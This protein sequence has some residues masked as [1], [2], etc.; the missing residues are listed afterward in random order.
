MGSQTPTYFNTAAQGGQNT[1]PFNNT[2]TSRQVSWFIGAGTMG[3]LPTAIL[4][5]DVYINFANAVTK[6]YPLMEIKLKISAGTG[7][8][9]FPTG[10]VETGFTTVFSGANFTL[11]TSQGQWTKFPLQTPFLWSNTSL[12]IIV[13]FQHNSTTGIGPNVNQPVTIAGPGSGRQWADFNGAVNTGTATNQVDFGIDGVP[14]LITTAVSCSALGSATAQAFGTG[15]FTYTWLPGM[16]TSSVVT[17]IAPGNHTVVLHDAGLNLTYT[18]P[19]TFTPSVPYTATVQSANITCAG[20]STGSAVIS[21]GGGS[22]NTG[23]QWNN[24]ITT[25][26]TPT[27]I[28]LAPGVYSV[29]VTDLVTGCVRNQ[30]FS[31]GQ[32]PP[33]SMTIAASSPTACVGG[34]VS[35]AAVMSG[36][37]PPYSYS[38]TA[39]PATA[40][41]SVTPSG[42]GP[43]VYTVTATDANACPSGATVGITSFTVPIVA[44]QDVSICPGETGTLVATG[45]TAYAWMP[46]GSTNPVFSAQPSVSSF[47]TVSGTM[48]G[49]SSEATAA[50]VVKPIP[51]LLYNTFSIT[52]ANLGSATVIP[53]GGIGPFTYTWLPVNQTGATVSGLNPNTYTVI[54][55]DNATGC[56]TNTT[57]TFGSL[58]PLTGDLVHSGSITCFGGTTGTGSFVNVAGGS[59]IQNYL[60]TN[61]TASLSTNT[62][63]TLSAGQWSLTVTDALTG[64]QVF[65]VFTI[66]QPPAATLTLASPVSSVCVGGS[67]VLT[68]TNSGG[69]PGYTYSWTGGPAAATRT[70]NEAT[71][72]IYVYTL[73]SA[74]SFSCLSVATI[75]VDFVPNPVV[76]LSNVSVCPLETG[77]LN[78][79]GASSYTWGNGSNSTT[80]SDAPFASKL[81]TVTGAALGCTS[82]ATASIVIKPLPV[83]LINSNSPR[84]ENGSLQLNGLGGVAYTWTGPNGFGS[85]LQNPLLNGLT[86]NNGGTY[87]LTV[88]AANSCTASVSVNVVVNPTPAVS[89]T[90]ATLCSG[91]NFVLLANSSPGVSYQWTGPSFSSSL[92]N[93]FISNAPVSA[94]GDYSVKVTSASGCSN[95]AVAKVLVVP[96]PSL[97][98]QLTSHS[99]CSQAFNGSPNTI[100]LTAGGATVYSLVT[101]PDM[102]NASP[103]GP[104]Y[105]LSAIPPNT[106]IASAT[107]SGSNGICTVTIA[108][109]F[110]IIPNPT[111]SVAS[112]TPQICAGQSYTYTSHGASSY[113]WS[114]A[115][116]GFTTY[117]N[118]GVA[119]AHPSINSVFSVYGGSLGCNSAS[120]T[121]TITVHPLPD[122]TLT[123][124]NP[125]ICY[126]GSVQLVAGGDATSFIWKPMTGLDQDNGPRVSASP[127]THQSYTVIGSA[128]NC[129]R[130]AV[131]TVLV[132]DLPEPV[133]RADRHTVCLND[134]IVLTG[135]GGNSYI[136]EA[137]GLLY[138]GKTVSFAARAW[139]NTNFTLTVTDANNCSNSTSVP[140]SVNLLP[141]GNLLG[142]MEGCI[143]FC[144]DVRFSGPVSADVISASWKIGNKS[145]SDG[146]FTHCFT[147]AGEHQVVGRIKNDLTG[148]VNSQTFLVR[149]FTKPRADFT[150]DPEKPVEG[151]GDVHFIN[152]SAGEGLGTFS[153]SFINDKGFRSQDENTSFYFSEAGIYPVAFVVEDEHGCADSVVKIVEIAPD[154]NFY[155]PDAFTPNGDSR[156]E[157]FMPVARA[158]RSYD[159][160]IFNRWGDLI[161]HSSDL[162]VGWDG[163]F[164]GVPCKQ[165]VYAWKVTLKT[166]QGE[167]R[168]YAGQVTLLR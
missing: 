65:S 75:S 73:N 14:L 72:A 26:T 66:T 36:G 13:Q 34:T 83:P 69:T 70:V 137:P 16:Q 2:T 128:N 115:I 102:F 78:V 103:A 142:N 120:Q 99:L 161:F 71:G 92:Q 56:T 100:T 63:A 154:F 33:V 112:T 7:M 114:S 153:W 105:P 51:S 166:L 110:S 138:A 109:T 11:A 123:P 1:F 89:A 62:V 130:S 3:N 119:V 129:T 87:N 91:Q 24:G 96:P 84:C 86:L 25:F 30:T 43:A 101:V 19:Q 108:L 135:S 58:I 98:A 97:T 23:Y 104:V 45:A 31:V 132:L 57:T 5:T 163:T 113:T 127:F 141:D 158:V 111:V 28:N 155:I 136:W 20:L 134:T 60:W 59:P 61:G 64:C 32:P 160:R 165:E 106:G 116:P 15:P 95:T 156:N 140:L 49:C 27:M 124:L 29:T 35:L 167:L 152:T 17:G 150:W 146:A 48:N 157:I 151:L 50:I 81:Y 46:G 40:Q 18:V 149:G 143:P 4:I 8:T 118:G 67:V 122:V 80:F 90:G 12:P 88:T 79:S 55:Y 52:C 76:S 38:W 22:G 54:V 139:H 10:P 41:Y 159:M 74:D 94:T 53:T 117:N 144:S 6:V 126:G 68:G 47:Y 9:G 21:I 121:T 145:Y 164:N 77:T 125:K 37:V 82:V 42:A 39:G 133:A 147:S 148:C 162:G 85:L 44:V 131:T 107:L 168:N 93:P